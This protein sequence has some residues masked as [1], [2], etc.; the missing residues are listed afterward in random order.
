LII[1]P[2]ETD[3]RDLL[4]YKAFLSLTGE[5]VSTATYVGDHGRGAGGSI[6]MRASASSDWAKSTMARLHKVG[7]DRH[8]CADM[9]R[10]RALQQ[11]PPFAGG[12]LV[13]AQVLDQS[14]ER[15][16]CDF[17]SADLEISSSLEC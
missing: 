4:M 6:N 9:V 13:L 17:R 8:R 5:I 16:G 1:R 3:T 12:P 11:F 14:R 15:S 2:D 7:D 10:V